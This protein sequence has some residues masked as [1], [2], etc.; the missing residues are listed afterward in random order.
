M[1]YIEAARE[2][3]R[4]FRRNRLRLVHVDDPADLVAL[5]DRCSPDSRYLRFHTGMA[6]LRPAMAAQL[7]SHDGCALGLR[8]WRGDL[9]ADARYTRTASGE[10]EMAVLVCD[11]FQGRGLGRALLAVLFEHAAAEGITTLSADALRSNEAI[12][13]LLESLAPVEVIG[14]SEGSHQLLI[15]LSEVAAAA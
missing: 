4:H 15:S 13:H 6:A 5:V 1:R 7:A 3:P 10:A 2:A 14:S 8:T 11:R 9:V 12:M